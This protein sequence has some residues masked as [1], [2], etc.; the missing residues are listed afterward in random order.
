MLASLCV[1]I[2]QLSTASSDCREFLVLVTGASSIVQRTG[3]YVTLTVV[4]TPIRNTLLPVPCLGGCVRHGHRHAVQAHTVVV[5]I[6]ACIYMFVSCSK[7]SPQVE[8]EAGGRYA[9]V[10]VGGSRRTCLFP[11]PIPNLLLYLGDREKRLC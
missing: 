6:S 3:R 2:M 4:D 7:V 10:E 5:T 1:Y 11:T 8:R 9:R